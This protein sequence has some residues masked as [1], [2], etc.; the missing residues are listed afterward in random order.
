MSETMIRGAI[1]RLE[2]KYIPQVAASTNF[3]PQDEYKRLFPLLEV[4]DKATQDPNI[5]E[6]VKFIYDKLLEKDKN[7][8]AD[9]LISV[10]T[11]IGAV[12]FGESKLDKIYKYFHLHK[13]AE[14]ALRYHNLLLDEL[15]ALEAKPSAPVV[16]GAEAKTGGV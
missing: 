12:Q 3:I 13:E 2:S 9:Y 4:W 5:Q 10:L 11:Q 7:N 15:K 6:R 14:K 1:S 8:P 16:E